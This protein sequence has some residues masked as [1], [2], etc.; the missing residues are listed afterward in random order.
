MKKPKLLCIVGPTS[1]GKTSAALAFAKEY[2]GEI[3]NA[4]ARQ[5]YQKTTIGT[6]KPVGKWEDKQEVNA[7]YV[8]NIAHHLMDVL[9]PEEHS[10][11]V[12]WH[13]QAEE[14]A[15][16][17]VARRH[18]PMLVGGTGLYIQAFVEGYVPPTVPP[19]MEWREKMGQKTLSELVA[20]LQEKDP[21][22]AAVV[23]LK[24]PYRVLRALEVCEYSG[25]SFVE[26]RK[27]H[28]S[29]Y[30]ILQVGFSFS[31]EQL[32]QRIESAIDGMLERG[33]VEEVRGLRL[34]G[35][36]ATAPAM[37]SLGYREINSFLDGAHTLIE[38]RAAII[39]STQQ[40]VKRQQTW[41][42]RDKTIHWF[43]TKQEMDACIRTWFASE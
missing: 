3:I 27:K 6:G 25:R 20:R 5:I 23:D 11:V 26:Q 40:Y 31:R 18:L 38:T 34:Q 36:P 13:E 15:E 4:D 14:I 2:N 37:T 21:A 12:T 43:S 10:N 30:D 16:A 33:W 28:V 32:Y 19:Q 41:F 7:Y 8:E 35:V 1:S 29:S 22:S 39:Q 9:A 42:K 24:N 17:I